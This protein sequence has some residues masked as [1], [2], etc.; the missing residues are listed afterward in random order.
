MFIFQF[1]TAGFFSRSSLNLVLKLELF[2]YS[3]TGL[4]TL[5]IFHPTGTLRITP[6]IIVVFNTH[7]RT[8]N[9]PSR[10]HFCQNNPILNMSLIHSFY[11]HIRLLWDDAF[12]AKALSESSASCPASVV[13]PRFSRNIEELPNLQLFLY[14]ERW[15]QFSWLEVDHM[16][17]DLDINLHPSH[18]LEDVS[19][20]SFFNIRW[21]VRLIFCLPHPV[22]AEKPFL[23]SM[24]LYVDTA[25]K[26]QSPAGSNT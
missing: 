2:I 11:P 19:K 21:I 24:L 4:L 1:I 9:N 14:L 16:I 7:R 25:F 5:T 23:D 22:M 20:V 8:H 12:H 17:G 13:M 6:S 3:K 15:V 18:I 26:T 10:L